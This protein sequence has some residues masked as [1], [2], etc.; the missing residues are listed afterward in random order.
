MREVVFVMRVKF[1]QSGGV[2]GAVRGCDLD[3]A[4]LAPNDARELES[5]VRASGITAS[6]DVRAPAARDLRLYEIR[7]ESDT[8][9]ATVTFDDETL[10]EQARPLVS[11]LRRNAKPQAG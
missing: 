3:T 11:F 9:N 4:L 1:L 8:V 10:P 7:V 2:V 5:L 6:N